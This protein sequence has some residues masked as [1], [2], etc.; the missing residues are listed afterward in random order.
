[1]VIQTR[2]V[3]TSLGSFDMVLVDIG[4]WFDAWE[5]R[6]AIRQE[7]LL[8]IRKD[9]PQDPVQLLDNYQINTAS[10]QHCRLGPFLH[11]YFTGASNP[12]EWR[13]VQYHVSDQWG[14]GIPEKQA[15]ESVVVV[16][17]LRQLEA[18]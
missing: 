10:Q 2:L 13:D 8:C 15:N 3:D 14:D 9:S 17:W 5:G 4:P 6:K 1:W 18:D 7:A 12:T 11:P 16:D